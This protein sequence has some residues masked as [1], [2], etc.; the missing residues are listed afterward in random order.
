MFELHKRKNGKLVI[1]EKH[2]RPLVY[3]DNW[4]L[5]DIALNDDY[6]ERFIKAMHKRGATLRVSIQNMDELNKQ[7]NRK[8]LEAILK[9]IDS[10]D[11]GFINIIADD[12][13]EK[14][15]EIIRISHIKHEDPI[16]DTLLIESR[17][18]SLELSK[19]PLNPTISEIISIA[20]TGT[21]VRKHKDTT[22]A[23]YMRGMLDSERN[24]SG[25][26]EELNKEFHRIK[27]RGKEHD[28]ATKELRDMA[29]LFIVINKTMKMSKSSE[30]Y[31]LNHVI[32]PVAY[33]DLVLIDKKW[34]TFVQQTGFKFPD[35]AMVFDRKAID[36]FFEELETN[37]FAKF[38]INWRNKIKR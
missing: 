25:G 14:E 8:Q 2:K 7:E 13:I 34:R 20:I 37:P 24:K 29:H 19:L 27:Q 21:P 33:C 23:E 4:A 30:W 5:S 9:M 32:V 36:E 22:F 1:K 10:V 15:D 12:V 17:L 31:D 26:I 18:A 35:I 3:L 6:R 28:A 11:S 38:N 16:R